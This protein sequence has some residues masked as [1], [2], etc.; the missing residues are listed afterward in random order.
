VTEFLVELYVARSD[1]AL[2]EQ[3]AERLRHAAEELTSEGMH[4]RFVRSI[5]VPEDETCFLSIEATSAH[6]A[7]EAARR[8]RLPF[9]RLT[10]TLVVPS[11]EEGVT[12][13]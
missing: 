13:G 12:C 8:A 7:G 9:D 11:A 4:V 3:C 6:G 2:V 10:E 1:A 5:F